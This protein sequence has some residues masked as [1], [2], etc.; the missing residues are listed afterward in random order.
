MA[1]KRTARS[2]P[3]RAASDPSS[4]VTPAKSRKRTRTVSGTAAESARPDGVSS[5]PSVSDTFVARGHADDKSARQGATGHPTEEDIRVRA[6]YRYLERGGLD[7][8]ALED[9]IL[10][11]EEFSAAG[12]DPKQRW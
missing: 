6:Y 3:E 2:E 7:G 8:G 9:W 5:A 12:D 1:K 11:E 4:A 10:A